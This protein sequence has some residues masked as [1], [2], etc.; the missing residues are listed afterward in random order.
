[1]QLLTKAQVRMSGVGCATAALA[2][3]A[4][5]LVAVRAQQGPPAAPA[6]RPMVPVAAS[7]IVL[8]AEEYYGENVSVM[9]AV[10]G[11]LSKTAFTVDQDK[12]RSTGK[13][14]LV[15][16]PTLTGIVVP[17]T[18]VTV[19]GEVIR[20]DPAEVAKKVKSYTLDL[21]AEAIA[22]YQGRPA[23]LATAVINA[24]LLDV[25]KRIPPPMTPAEAAYD[26]VMKQVGTT[27]NSLRAG[28]EAP[29]ADQAKEQVAVLKKAFGEAEAFFKTRGTTDAIGWAQD[30]QKLVASME[31][32][33]AG[34]KWDDMKT[35]VTNLTQL[36]QTCHTAHRERLDDGTF[37]IK[38]DR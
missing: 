35:S 12:S 15:L 24:A 5:S 33:V 11:V 20:F 18:Y 4:A 7:T 19:V 17:N 28:L 30:A 21:P 32:A 16:A 1:M 3:S 29:N 23:I 9:A 22:K 10:E 13:D 31:Q 14:V 34:A 36:C 6:A 38:G 26:K 27:F 8:R 25:A 37:R 2:L